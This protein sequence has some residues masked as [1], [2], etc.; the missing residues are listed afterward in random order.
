MSFV[1]SVFAI[2]IAGMA[3]SLAIVLVANST[4]QKRLLRQTQEEKR[5]LADILTQADGR[6]RR[7]DLVVESQQVHT[8][9]GVTDS[10]IVMRQYLS[11]G[12]DQSKPLPVHRL[13]IHGDKIHVAGMKL[14]FGP[15]A[16]PVDPDYQ[17]L[18]DRTLLYFTQVGGTSLLPPQ[19]PS[20]D[21]PF[22]F[23][24][25]DL[26]PQ[27]TRLDPS[28]PRPTFY[29]TRL[30]QNLWNILLN[31]QPGT[32]LSSPSS[33]PPPGATLPW[34]FPISSADL[35]VTW[36]K[37]AE[38]TLRLGHIYTA[39]IS[40]EDVITLD[41]DKLPCIPNLLNILLDEARTLPPTP[42]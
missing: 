18:R 37:P 13:L 30:W 19:P 39:F 6:I 25:A 41:E 9:A 2:L 42:P 4:R 21:Q 17:P 10:T 24:P 14:K 35:A 1:R 23:T 8:L 5:Q 3:V 11:L 34:T 7:L 40:I 16:F 27:L 31:S 28:E 22:T 20:A 32:N 33:F 38:R 36:M 29:E 15:A 12:T 26:P